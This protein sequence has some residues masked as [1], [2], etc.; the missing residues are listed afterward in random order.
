M[1]KDNLQPCFIWS[2]EH[3]AWWRANECG[4]TLARD[5]RGVYEIEQAKAIVLGANSHGRINEAIVPFPADEKN[6]KNISI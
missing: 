1:N 2:F 3:N 4:Y 5:E 6:W